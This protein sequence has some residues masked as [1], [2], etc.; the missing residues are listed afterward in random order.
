MSDLNNPIPFPIDEE[1]IKEIEL[2]DLSVFKK[3]H[4]RILMHCLEVFKTLLSNSKN[5]FVS[6]EILFN[7][8]A[9]QAKDF[10]DKQFTDKL[11]VQMND[12]LIMLRNYSLKEGKNISDLHINDLVDLINS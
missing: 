2:L 7:W 3:H 1:I 10:H 6:K 4:L 8:C 5:N 11:Y 12:V 9:T